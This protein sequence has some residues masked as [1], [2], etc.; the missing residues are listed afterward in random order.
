MVKVR[1]LGTLWMMPPSASPC[2]LSEPSNL[3][4]YLGSDIKKDADAWA[5]AEKVQNRHLP[6][7]I[8]PVQAGRQQSAD[9]CFNLMGQKV[10]A[11][12]RGLFI[13]NGKLV[14]KR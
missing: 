1:P 11:P 4:Y 5:E 2:L 10:E 8:V 3:G 13:I 6:S 7:A 12:A 9:G 14:I